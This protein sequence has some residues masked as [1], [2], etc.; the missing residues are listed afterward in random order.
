MKRAWR[1]LVAACITSACSPS[2]RSVDQ[3]PLAWRDAVVVD[4]LDETCPTVHVTLDG[5]R[6][7]FVVDTGAAMTL[8]DPRTARDLALRVRNYKGTTTTKGADG[9]DVVIDRCAYVRRLGLG[10][11]V[12]ENVYVSLVDTDV[13]RESHVGGI[14]GQDVLGRLAIVVDRERRKLHVLPPNSDRAAVQEYLR[15]AKLGVGEWA[16][17]ELAFRPSPFLPL[18]VK[19]LPGGGVGLEIDTGATNTSIPQRAVDALQLE[20]TGVSPVRT[21]HGVHE[22][23]DYRLNRFGLFGLEISATV[24]ATPT[25]SGLLGM[26]IL[27]QLV[28]VV[29]GPNKTVWLHRRVPDAPAAEATS[30]SAESR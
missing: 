28:L 10:S 13:M 30:S 23:R 17:V 22:M 27:G 12:I 29:D 16:A 3:A 21:I 1:A 9:N 24:H 6:E 14:L 7:P 19:G 4:L 8:L 26:D 5:H 11:L 20:S 25:D 2:F 18:D 15:S